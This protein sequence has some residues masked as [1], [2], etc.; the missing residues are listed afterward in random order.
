MANDKTEKATPRKREEARKKG[1]VAKSPDLNGAIVLLAA[2]L[3]LSAFGPAMLERMEES[4][5]EVLALVA[6]PD[7]VGRQGIGTVLAGVF[8]A[9]AR[10]AGPVIGVC[11]F[12]GVAVNVVQTG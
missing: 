1:Q 12:A 5:R 4:M 6:T 11:A 8:G 7:V 2:L 9:A 3:A 10:S